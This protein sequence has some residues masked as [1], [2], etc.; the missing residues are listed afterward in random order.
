[1]P[2]TT[3]L[4]IGRGVP[5]VVGVAPDRPGLGLPRAV[6]KTHGRND[7][8]WAIHSQ[9]NSPTRVARR[10]LRVAGENAP[11]LPFPTTGQT[12]RG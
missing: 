7:T 4:V 3:D 2:D 11:S 1:M 8:E 6:R 5:S 9:L 10:R 12:G